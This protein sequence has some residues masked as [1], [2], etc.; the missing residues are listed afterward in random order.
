MMEIVG[1][2]YFLMK[3]VFAGIIAF[4]CA[5]AF[6]YGC[7]L[8]T[9]QKS[10]VASTTQATTAAADEEFVPLEEYSTTEPEKVYQYHSANLSATFSIPKGWINKYML[11][12]D[13]NEKGVKFIQFYE[14][15][16]RS[17]NGR[18][19]LFTFKL[20]PVELYK[21]KKTD[22][23]YGTVLDSDDVT[24]YVVRSVPSTTQ[25]DKKSKGLTQSYKALAKK[26]YF[27]SICNSVVFDGSCYFDKNGFNTE[28]ATTEPTTTQPEYTFNGD[29][30]LTIPTVSSVYTT[31]TEPAVVQGGLVFDDISSRRLTDSEV[32]ALSVEQ[33]QQAINDI[34]AIH[35]YNFTFPE[36][37]EHYRQ[38]SWYHPSDSYSEDDFS[39]IEKYNFELLQKYRN[40]KQS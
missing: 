13:I 30:T 7:Q 24:Y 4:V 11:I 23:H 31:A 21:D 12:D 14:K 20:Y 40:I 15:E 5:S 3:K 35:G 16:N 32:N 37:A 36:Y 19:L 34:C 2:R 8:G 29:I 26:K 39:E 28:P 27:D 9:E 6:L 17:I 38:F 22:S 25:Y 33:I 18:G 1:R 10:H